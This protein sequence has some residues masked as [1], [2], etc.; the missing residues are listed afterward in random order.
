[1]GFFDSLF[2][3]TRRREAPSAD[4]RE[5]LVREV[6][7]ELEKDRSV[8]AV[9]YLPDAFALTVQVH[10]RE[11][12][13]WLENLFA[14]TREV[15]PEERR[16]LVRRFLG[17]MS[18]EPE[19]TWEEVERHLVPVVRAC[20]YGA[21]P[22]GL[23]LASSWP[24]RPCVPFLDATLAVDRP[25]SIEYVTR[26]AL[27]KWRVREDEAFATAIANAATAAGPVEPYASTN[28]PIWHVPGEDV[29]A[30]SRLFLP[31]WLDSMRDRVEGR[32][33]AIIP[34]RST[35]LVGGD[36]RP[37]MVRWL[38]EKA[39]REFEASTRSISPAV[40]TVD[41]SGAV[42]PY[43][44]AG[45]GEIADLVRTGHAKLLALTY[46][47]QKAALDP[48]YE[49]A[50]IDVFVASAKLL[51]VQSRSLSWCVWTEGVEALLPRTD[52]VIVGAVDSRGKSRWRANVPFAEAMAI[53]APLWA[54]ADLPLGPQRFRVS[55]TFPRDMREAFLAASRPLEEIAG[56]C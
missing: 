7:L 23:E 40:Y 54:T 41:E 47:E 49:K 21:T 45:A 1:M 2:K 25:G 33:L 28:G 11:H 16:E 8:G 12:M 43:A 30:S 37:E 42:I 29:Y 51:R 35:V 53:G 38:A 19:T 5:R 46:E 10:E 32:P 15:S 44:P 36:A 24:R 48:Y 31:G 27:E 50:Q 14:E 52:L 3:K 34:E 13:V 39:I 4:P 20:T 17:A 56:R 6:R 55:G 9:R 18:L 26:A 22:E